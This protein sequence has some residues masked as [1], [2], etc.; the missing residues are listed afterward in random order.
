[1]LTLIVPGD[2]H[3][4]ENTSE[5][6][7][8]GDV[9]LELEHSLVSLS[10]WESKYEKPFLGRDEK[11]TEEV[12]SYVETMLLT[13]EV[14][15]GILHKLSEENFNQINDY[16]DAKMTA[17]WFSDQPSA[18]RSREVITAELIYYWMIVFNIPFECQYW[19]LNK[20]F[21]LIR[22]CNVKQAKPEKMSRNEVAQ[23]NRE[24]NA[25]RRKQLGTTG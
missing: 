16:L 7:T 18:P 4:D 11:T 23:R 14:P 3:F 8:V 15:E 25:Q 20:L 13:E 2:E 21:T 19:H 22:I 10:K 12:I 5:F 24:L 6:V 1:M 9:T 17:T